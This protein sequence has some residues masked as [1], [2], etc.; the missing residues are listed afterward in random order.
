M[1]A[2]KLNAPRLDGITSVYAHDGTVSQIVGVTVQS[3]VTY[4]LQ[5]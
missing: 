5:V 3:G 4:T 2:P 1:V